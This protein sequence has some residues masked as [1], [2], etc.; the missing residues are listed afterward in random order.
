M[1]PTRLIADDV[2][3]GRL[4]LPFAGPALPARSYYTYIPAAHR[5]DPVVRAF[6]EWLATAA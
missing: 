3:A 5:D 6:C 1:G 2:T 4:V